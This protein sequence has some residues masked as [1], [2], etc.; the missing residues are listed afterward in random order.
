VDTGEKILAMATDF[1]TDRLR[2]M[3]AATDAGES[4]PPT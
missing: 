4:W 2:Q 3:I 1:V